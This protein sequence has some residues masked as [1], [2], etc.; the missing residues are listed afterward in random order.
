MPA[1]DD[2]LE[3]LEIRLLLEAIH[4]RYGYDLREYSAASLRRRILGALSRSGLPDLGALQHALL[5]DPR[6]FAQVIE[7]LTVQVSGLFRDPHFFL[8]FRER[9]VPVLRTYPLLRIWHS[10][11]STGEEVYG[12]AILLHETGLY[13]RSQ[14][15]ATD[16]SAQALAQ[17]KQGTYSTEHLA[18]YEEGYRTSGGTGSFASYCTEAYGGIAMRESLRRNILFFQHDLVSDHVFGEMHV[19]FC[20]NVMI[21]F[22]APLR[23]KVLAKLAQSLCP[24]GFLCL[25]SSERLRDLHLEQRFSAFSAEDRIYRH[26][27]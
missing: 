18:A 27:E 22:G 14:I 8:T 10:G 15:Y 6:R 7:G 5:V 4:E 20:R 17:A 3:A 25:G 2:G 23:A 1:G 13:D 19:I 24:G 16:L 26:E 12:T 21:Y 9:V 11:C